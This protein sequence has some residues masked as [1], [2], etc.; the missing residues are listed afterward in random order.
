MD[1]LETR[2]RQRMVRSDWIKVGKIE[3][4]KQAREELAELPEG[5]TSPNDDLYIDYEL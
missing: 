1:A 4:D 3:P 2:T 5:F